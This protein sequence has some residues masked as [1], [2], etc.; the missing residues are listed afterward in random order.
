MVFSSSLTSLLLLLLVPLLLELLLLS[1][2]A[3]LL[4]IHSGRTVS[5]EAEKLR[6]IWSDVIAPGGL[7]GVNVEELNENIMG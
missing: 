6:L 1:V 2:L 3:L 7:L 4:I 5:F